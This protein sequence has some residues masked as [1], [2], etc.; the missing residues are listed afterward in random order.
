MTFVPHIRLSMLGDLP[1]GEQFSCSLSLVPQGD[2]WQT[3]LIGALAGVDPEAAVDYAIENYVDQVALND[4]RDDCVAFWA[5]SGSMIHSTAVL[6]RVKMATIGADGTYRGHAVEAAANQ[7]GQPI[8]GGVPLPSNVARKTTLL[9]NGDLGRVKGGFFLPALTTWGYDH[10]TQ[11]FSTEIVQGVQASVVQLI[12]DLENAPGFDAE[13]FRVVV[14]SQ[15]RH[16]PDGSV[17]RPP[18]NHDVIGVSVGRRTDTQR[19]RLNKVSE[20]RPTA[21]LLS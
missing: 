10:A 3:L 7:P 1:A 13:G 8:N 6:K 9:T 14:A 12:N 2:Q 15:G 19:R 11:L 18:T 20:A 5:R 16:N 4:I 17:R 21:T